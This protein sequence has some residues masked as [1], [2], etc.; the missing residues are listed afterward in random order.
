MRP[1]LHSMNILHD[2]SAAARVP[3]GWAPLALGFRPFFLLAAI[4]AVLLLV[5]WS[6]VW[7]GRLHP[8]YY[9]AVAWHAHEMLFGYTTAVIA[10]FLLTAVRNW[11][12]V[13][14][15]TGARL[16]GLAAV[17]LAARILP[18]IDGVSAVVVVVVDTAFLPLLAASL[19]RPLWLATNRVNRVIV[20]LLGAMAVA[21]LS[22]HL[23]LL[24]VMHGVGDMR[25]VMLELVLLLLVLVA[26]RVLPSF[27]QNAIPTF[28]TR[29]RRW[30]E[31][32]AF[33]TLA[34]VVI[35]E[36]LPQSPPALGASAW[37]L[38][39]TVHVLRLSG[40]FDRR[41]LQVPVLWVLHA[42][43]VW[44]CVGAL[45]NAAALSGWASP[46]S[47]L[48]ALT[49]GAIGVFTIGMMARVTRGHTG[50][51][52]DVEPRMTIAFLL[53]N[54]AVIVRVFAVWLLPRHHAT[55]ID[56]S[57][58]MWVIAFAVFLAGHAKML[59]RPRV[60]GRPG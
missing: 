40:W 5:S 34:P 18:W 13:Q 8:A 45:L 31:V 4:V 36:L 21:N 60:D 48:H 26:G 42:G 50:R 24:G 37:A 15:W 20:P 56:L 52:I 59:V 27:T 23:Q 19:V 33:A 39:G 2:S 41:V 10:G 44:L 29:G 6:F 57:A 51:P 54:G 3:R 14:T 58:A 28:R 22:S 35:A 17:W 16:A 32:A 12:G 38:F 53:I 47:A 7:R 43:Y 1:K 46:S 30:V 25:R 9:D 49:I 11:S 55:W